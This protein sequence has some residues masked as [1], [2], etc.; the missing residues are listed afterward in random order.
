MVKKEDYFNEKISVVASEICSKCFKPRFKFDINIA[1]LL[2]L[3][4]QRYFTCDS[5]MAFIPSAP[6]IIENIMKIVLFFNENKRPVLFTRHYNT[7][8][9]AK[10]MGKWWSRLMKRGD[11]LNKL[12]PIF[13]EFKNKKIVFKSQ[14]DAFYNTNAEAILKRENSCQVVVT[15]VMTHICCET[16]VRSAFV[17]GFEVFVPA[18]ATASYNKEFYLYSLYNMSHSCANIVLSHDILE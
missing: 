3:D 6:A 17:R 18:D 15:G 4:M 11:A 13:D 12:D 2:V 5:S 8:E 9:N 7:P 14:Y 16:T 1:G 10:M